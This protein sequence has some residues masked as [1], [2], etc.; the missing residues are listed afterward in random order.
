MCKI[1]T[2]TFCAKPS[3]FL[4]VDSCLSIFVFMIKERFTHSKDSLSLPAPPLKISTNKK[5]SKN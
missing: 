4:I 3:L 2:R 5:F 1:I